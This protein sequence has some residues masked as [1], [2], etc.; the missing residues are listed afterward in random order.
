MHSNGLEMFSSV[1][2]I[3]FQILILF[4]YNQRHVKMSADQNVPL[5]FP[6]VREP[7]KSITD[8]ES[9]ECL[10]SCK[11]CFS[12]ILPI[13]VSCKNSSSTYCKAVGP[14]GD[15]SSIKKY[16]YIYDFSCWIG[17]YP[18]YFRVIADCVISLPV[19]VRHA[20]AH[21]AKHVAVITV[22]QK[23]DVHCESVIWMLIKLGIKV[24]VFKNNISPISYG[25]QLSDAKDWLHQQRGS[26]DC[27]NCMRD[28]SLCRFNLPLQSPDPYTSGKILIIVRIGSE[29]RYVNDNGTL[30]LSIVD[31]FKQKFGAKRISTYFGNESAS[32]VIQLFHNAIVVIGIHGAGVVNTL[33]S[34]AEKTLVLE[35]TPVPTYLHTYVHI[36]DTYIRAYL[37]TYQIYMHTF[38]HIN[39]YI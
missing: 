20:L 1:R 27:I 22:T 4:W 7:N 17:V 6:I 13:L 14:R 24:T 31:S 18:G 36:K 37:P 39:I 34:N 5:V 12:T 33:F 28:I 32:D 3:L 30:D 19:F 21:R 29:R 15:D 38:I 11:Y 10:R 23:F 9:S 26:R 16:D 8:V 25:L 35:I 2:S